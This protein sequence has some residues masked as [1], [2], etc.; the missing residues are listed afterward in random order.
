MAT[1]AERFPA[2]ALKSLC[3]FTLV[4]TRKK[5]A[6]VE[7][8]WDKSTTPAGRETALT[9]N[10]NR[11]QCNFSNHITNI[12]AST[13]SCISMLTNSAVLESFLRVQNVHKQT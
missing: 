11:S 2:A 1:K 4:L 10:S 6:L 7:R 8:F 13:S 3:N 9:I 5:T 12:N